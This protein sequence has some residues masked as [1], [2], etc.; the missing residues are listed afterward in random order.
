MVP[1]VTPMFCLNQRVRI[2]NN[3]PLS[4]HRGTVVELVGM[5]RE[6][7]PHYPK[8]RVDVDKRGPG[9]VFYHWEIVAA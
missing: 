1:E 3:S 4:G 8:F 5:D 6:E 7:N 2:S 9:F